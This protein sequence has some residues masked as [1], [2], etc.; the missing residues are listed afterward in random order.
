MRILVLGMMGMLLA[1][2]DPSALPPSSIAPICEALIGPIRYNSADPKSQ[3]FAAKLLVM[4]LKER[5]Q[6]GQRL[7]CPTYKKK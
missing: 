3:R 6:I 1:G 2:C 4:D 5:N 7:N